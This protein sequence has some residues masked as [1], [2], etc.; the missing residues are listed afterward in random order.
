M[1][2][3]DSAAFDTLPIVPCPGCDIHVRL[4][5]DGDGNLIMAFAKPDPAGDLE[6]IAWDKAIVYAAPVDERT[7]PEDMGLRL[8]SHVHNE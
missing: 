7:A 4:V 3:T 1:S 8:R 6:I 2:P 5:N